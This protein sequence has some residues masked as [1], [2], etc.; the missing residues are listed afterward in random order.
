M[1]LC[2]MCAKCGEL[3]LKEDLIFNEQNYQ[4]YCKWCVTGTRCRS[5]PKPNPEDYQLDIT[6]NEIGLIEIK[7]R[8]TR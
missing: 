2:G 5:V 4:F 8:E 3:K 7:R 1:A 6:W